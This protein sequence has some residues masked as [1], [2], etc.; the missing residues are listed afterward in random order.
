[1][2]N[3]KPLQLF[4]SESRPL[5]SKTYDHYILAE[6][7]SWF[8]LGYLPKIGKVRNVLDPLRFPGSEV[9]VNVATSGDTVVQMQKFRKN[10]NF[11][12]A[13][14]LRKWDLIFLSGGGND[15]IDALQGDYLLN[16]ELV[17][18]LKKNNTTFTSAIEFIDNVMFDRVLENIKECYVTICNQ[19]N[20]ANG[21]LNISTKIIAHCYDHITPRNAPVKHFGTGPWVYDGLTKNR[22]PDKYWADIEKYVFE[23]FEVF[24]ISLQS[25]IPNFEVIP[26]ISRSVLIKAT[27]GTSGDSND[28][29]NE[30]H[31]NPKGYKKFAQSHFQPIVDGL[32]NK[33]KLKKVLN[34]KS[35]GKQKKSQKN[36][37]KKLK[38]EI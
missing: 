2:S 11:I 1:M 33:S 27:P 14:T 19:R 6:G 26:T 38:P 31:P 7:D 3:Q 36:L 18:I 12:S 23:K 10:L 20:L 25:L 34:K 24:M 17:S 15:L 29:A 13:L 22:I 37:F 21:Q 32:Y 28:W 8:N 35:S 4:I 9:I 30:I 16:Y 5:L